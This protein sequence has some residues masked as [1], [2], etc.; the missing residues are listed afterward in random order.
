V[1]ESSARRRRPGGEH[2]VVDDHGGV[3]ARRGPEVAGI[4]RQPQQPGWTDM[5]AAP[6]RPG[7]CAEQGGQGPRKARRRSRIEAS[8]NSTDPSG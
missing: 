4:E 2:D 5:M 3:E 6:P 8:E 7:R 1:I